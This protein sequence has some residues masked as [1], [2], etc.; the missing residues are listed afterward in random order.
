MDNNTQG[1]YGLRG[2]YHQYGLKPFLKDLKYP[3][4][5]GFLVVVISSITPDLDTYILIR[6]ILDMSMTVIPIIIT[7]ILSSYTIFIS[8]FT[9]NKRMSRYEVLNKTLRGITSTYAACLINSIIFLG[10]LFGFYL[11]SK[12]GVTSQ[13]FSIV[14]IFVIFFV[15]CFI[16]YPF[17]VLINIIIDMFNSGN[18][19]LTLNN[20]T[21]DELDK[22]DENSKNQ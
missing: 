11:F 7:L 14:N 9:T 17:V 20:F 6:E 19:S 21:E 10:V 3:S 2:I 12:L 1:K 18:M 22:I 15:V 8:L 5:L 16:S 4:L 13:Y